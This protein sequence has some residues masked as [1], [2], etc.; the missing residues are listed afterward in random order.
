[1]STTLLSDLQDDLT[2]RLKADGYFIDIPVFDEVKGD[3]V[4]KVEIALSQIT[5]TNNKMGVCAVVRQFECNDKFADSSFGPMDILITVSVIEH[6]P[7]NTGPDGTQKSGLTIARRVVRV[8]KHYIPHGL[9]NCLICQNPTITAERTDNDNVRVWNVNFISMES[10]AESN[11]KVQ[12]PVIS[13]T[14]GTAPKTVT[15]TCATASAS[16][17]Y[18][19]DGTHPHSLNTSATMYSGPFVV[20]SAKTVRA[21]AFKSGY[22]GSDVI[23]V[24]YS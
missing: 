6:V 19:T 1:M 20:S 8:L 2:E 3:I 5:P 12:T 23:S 13:P 18:T 15:I 16:I 10:D 9:S 4:S 11:L 14:T 7:I 17:Y 21:A 24:T 22:I